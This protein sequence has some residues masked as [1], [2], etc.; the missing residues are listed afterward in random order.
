M[1]AKT[2]KK[3]HTKISESGNNPLFIFFSEIERQI[4]EGVG[5]GFFFEEKVCDSGSCVHD[6][7]RNESPIMTHNI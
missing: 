5:F 6:S 4:F 7:Y 3:K 1:H 2:N